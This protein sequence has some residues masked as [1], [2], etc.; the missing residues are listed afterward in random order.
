M[1]R[2][3]STPGSGSTTRRSSTATRR[4]RWRSSSSRSATRRADRAVVCVVL[5]AVGDRAFCSGGNTKEY[6]EYYAGNPPEYLQYMRLFNDMVTGHPA[7]RQAGDLPRQRAARRR[8]AGDRHGVRLLDRRRPRALRPGGSAARLGARRRLD[9]LPAPLR[10]LRARDRELH[11]VRAVVGATR[12][13]AS[14]CSTR[15]CRCSTRDGRFI[16]NPLVVT[17][18]YVDETGRS[19]SASRSRRSARRRR[20][21]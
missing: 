19:S 9:R 7:L 11:A 10:R 15:S 6:A 4:A 21:R 12:R 20:R 1:P 8:R 3:V 17:D 13:C 18:R 2:A 14:G 5:T 16:P